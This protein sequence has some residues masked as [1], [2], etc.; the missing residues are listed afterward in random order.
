MR[1]Q[2]DEPLFA[3]VL[4][5]TSLACY[6]RVKA[7]SS[8]RTGQPQGPCGAGGDGIGRTATAR[9][10]GGGLA[11]PAASLRPRRRPD[12]RQTGDQNRD[13]PMKTV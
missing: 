7:V 12:L 6:D 3:R 11:G 13:G 8:A 1:A 10:R 4:P 9:I 5:F 2:D